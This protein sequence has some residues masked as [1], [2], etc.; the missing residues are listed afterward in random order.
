MVEDLLKE[1]KNMPKTANDKLY[2]YEVFNECYDR[3]KNIKDDMVIFVA[4]LSKNCWLEDEYTKCS[5]GDYAEY[6]L[7]GIYDYDATLEELND[8]DYS[9][10][11][12]GLDNGNEFKDL[13][14]F[15]NIGYEYAFT[16]IDNC[17]YYIKNGEDGFYI[18]N[19]E[20]RLIKKP[21]PMDNDIETIMDLLKEDKIKHISYFSHYRIRQI[22]KENLNYE[23]GDY[24]LGIDNYKKYCLDRYIT[25]EDI[26]KKLTEKKILNENNVNIDLSLTEIDGQYTPINKMGRLSKYFHNIDNKGQSYHYVASLNNGT[27]YYYKKDFY[28]ALDKNNIVKEFSEKKHFL[29]KELVNNNKFVYITD[30]EG[31]KIANEIKDDYNNILE[32][33]KS[34]DNILLDNNFNLID[35]FMEYQ[36]L[37]ECNYFENYKIYRFFKSNN[38]FIKDAIEK[39]VKSKENN[40][41]IKMI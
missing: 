2:Y 32:E 33:S 34:K 4:E 16:T 8:L 15:N 28:L 23:A 30:E 21:T 39:K 10:I 35:K 18:T 5:I 7:S 24:S 14:I 26:I 3:D 6:I 9:E 25:N 41:E 1:Y 13:L 19:P 29:L 37:K 27:D 17:K 12:E 11:V 22:I 36:Q 20:D 38:E 40:N 31:K